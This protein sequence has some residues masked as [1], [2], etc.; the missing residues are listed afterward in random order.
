MMTSGCGDPVLAT[1][2]IAADANVRSGP[3]SGAITCE[4]DA[5]L[6]VGGFGHL[7]R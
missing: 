1:G 7:R 4:N 5:P 2:Q 6:G 3:T